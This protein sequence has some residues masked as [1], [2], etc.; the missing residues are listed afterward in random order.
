MKLTCKNCKEEVDVSMY[1]YDSQIIN[2][3]YFL[4]N[5]VEYTAV[6][7]GKAICPLCGHEMHEY[8]KSAISPREIIELAVGKEMG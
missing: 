7:R 6:T 8:F 2:Q 1:F 3:T 4:S 5:T